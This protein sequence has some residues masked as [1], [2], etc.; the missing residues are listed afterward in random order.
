M[1]P[2]LLVTTTIMAEQIILVEES[3]PAERILQILAVTVTLQLD[4]KHYEN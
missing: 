1:V 2:A 3:A 4:H